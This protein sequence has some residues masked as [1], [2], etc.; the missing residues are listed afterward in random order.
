MLITC[1]KS[2]SFHLPNLKN[3]LLVEEVHHLLQEKMLEILMLPISINNS[4]IINEDHELLNYT[5]LEK[6][7]V[8]LFISLRN[9]AM[10]I[11]II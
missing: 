5:K 3:L 1:L 6:P 10:N 11:V 9:K 7:H 4:K 8:Q 2:Q